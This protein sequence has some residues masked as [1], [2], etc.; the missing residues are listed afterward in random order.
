MSWDITLIKTS[1]NSEDYDLSVVNR[2][3]FDF[4]HFKKELCDN[5]YNVECID[6][7]L[8]VYDTV[9]F[10]AK[11]SIS[12]DMNI[13]VCFHIKENDKSVYTFLNE[14]CD[15]FDCRAFDWGTA[16][17]IDEVNSDIQQNTVTNLP[18]KKLN[19]FKRIFR[20]K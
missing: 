13:D 14:L 18:G 12:H 8:L 17:F 1:T 19:I 3:E 7:N 20:I 2:I 4:D 9:D 16:E 5:Y 6:N 10:E 11:F 15:I